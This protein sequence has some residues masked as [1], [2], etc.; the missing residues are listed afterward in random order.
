MTEKKFEKKIGFF[1]SG[2][3]GLTVFK[4][5]KEIMPNAEYLYFGDLKNIPYGEKSQ[6]ELIEIADGIFKFFESKQVDA[7]V[8]ACNT[9]S[10]TVYDALKDKYSFKIYPIIQSCA[11]VIA[12]MDIRKIGVFATNA[13]TK[14]HAYSRELKKFNPDLEV[15]EIAC[16][17]WVKIVEEGL[18]DE[19]ESI[20]IIKKYVD[21]MME[22]SPDKII[23]GCTHYPYLLEVLAKFAEREIFIDPSRY[24]AEFILAEEKG[25]RGKEKEMRSDDRNPSTLQPFNLPAKSE[26]FFVSANPE[27]FKEASKMFYEV[28]EVELVNYVIG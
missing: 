1:D 9:T 26:S 11:E 20:E 10:A 18:Q 24:F 15:F 28:K 19:S 14:S 12:G 17:E 27:H 5:L 2:V 8:M 7:V 16:P 4:A 25:K 23:L 13:T 21:E 22:N 6:E 3:G